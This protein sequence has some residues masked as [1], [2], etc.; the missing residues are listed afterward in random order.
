[1]YQ[2]ARELS[3]NN[4]WKAQLLMATATPQLV[5]QSCVGRSDTVARHAE[6]FDKCAERKGVDAGNMAR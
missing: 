2:L 6:E 5:K 3:A 4:L 1:V